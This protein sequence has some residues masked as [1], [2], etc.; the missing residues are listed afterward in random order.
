ML[1]FAAGPLAGEEHAVEL[2]LY[3]KPDD[4]LLDFRIYA[5]PP[6]VRA[7]MSALDLNY[8]FA[9]DSCRLYFP[10][11]AGDRWPAAAR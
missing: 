6:G 8:C 9:M 10:F 3:G 2:S 4:V 5:S 1:W 11:E 7:V